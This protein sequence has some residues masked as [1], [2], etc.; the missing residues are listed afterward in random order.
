M[1]SEV[2]SNVPDHAFVHGSPAVIK[3]WLSETG[4]KLKFNEKGIAYCPKSEKT[5]LLK[6]DVVTE[7]VK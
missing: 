3:H 4:R 5:Y 7:V 1:E 2:C 6:N